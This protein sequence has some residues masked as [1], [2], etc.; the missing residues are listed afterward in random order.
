MWK[1]S[2]TAA[3]IGLTA[4]TAL[5]TI[6]APPPTG[7]SQVTGSARAPTCMGEPATIVA[8]E[9]FTEGTSGPD[10]IV[11]RADG[12]DDIDGHGGRDLVCTRGGDDYVYDSDARRDRIRLG[13]GRDLVSYQQG[14]ATAD[15]DGGPESDLVQYVF[16]AHGVR[17]NLTEATDSMGNRLDRIESVRGTS[18][19]D[20]FIGTSGPNLLDGNGGPDRIRGLEGPDHLIGYGG[21]PHSVLRMVGGPGDDRLVDAWLRSVLLGGDGDDQLV[22]HRGPDRLNGGAGDDDLRAGTG[23]DRSRGGPGHDRLLADQ[24]DDR[25]S[26]GGGRDTWVNWVDDSSSPRH[27]TRIDLRRGTVRDHLP[28]DVFH[29]RLV[30]IELVRGDGQVREIVWG[31]RGPDVISTRGPNDV[32]NG[33]GGDDRL[34]VFRQGR[35]YGR[36]D[37]GPGYDVCK[38]DRKRNCEARG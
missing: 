12:S 1:L 7:A 31:T 35:T 6:G 19:R 36:V 27:V 13:D 2:R 8:T 5:V 20:V 23:D 9:M 38:A 29:D 14:R 34:T 32:L 28:D 30:G 26:G 22:A 11:G 16:D 21:N 33:R 3:G 37:G 17:V 10:V 24:G 4:A 18:L 25:M 15:V